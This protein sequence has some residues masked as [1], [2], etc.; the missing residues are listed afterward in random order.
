MNNSMNDDL[1]GKFFSNLK[2]ASKRL[3]KHQMFT[4][5][6]K[7]IVDYEEG[8]GV[9]FDTVKASNEVVDTV[10]AN[11][12]RIDET[13]ITLA[14]HGY[15]KEATDW[16]QAECYLLGIKITEKLHNEAT[17]FKDLN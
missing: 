6:V 13:L 7:A 14:K 12:N 16:V 9:K 4:Q 5:V 15:I 1:L 2:D 11:F 10:E 3:M 17:L 8:N